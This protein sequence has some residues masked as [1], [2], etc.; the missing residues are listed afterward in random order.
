MRIEHRIGPSSCYAPETSVFDAALK[1]KRAGF[2]AFEIHLDDF[3]GEIG[4]PWLVNYAG[5]WPRTFDEERRKKLKKELQGF[6]I[7]IVHGTPYEVNIATQ[8]PGLREESIRQYMEAI[9]FANDIGASVVTFHMGHPSFG[10]INPREVFNRNVHFA[11]KAAKLAEEYDLMMGY[12]TGSGIEFWKKLLAAIGS[13]RFGMLLDVAHWIMGNNRDM[14]NLMTAIEKFACQIVEVHVHDVISW[15]ALGGRGLI[16]HYAFGRGTCIDLPRIVRKLK[17][18]NYE[19]PLIFEIVEP[20][21]E[22]M[23]QECGR[24]KEII[25]K[26]WNEG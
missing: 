21:T 2:K 23:L 16:D 18:V 11:K 24:A 7:V 5:V 10:L 22:R 20:T 26:T 9:E 15:A 4:K 6:S 17:E 12:E 3:S 14:D 13:D 25:V 19:G 8:N 1:T